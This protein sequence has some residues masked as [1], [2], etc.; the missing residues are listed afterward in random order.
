MKG[1]YINSATIIGG[2]YMRV[3]KLEVR[4]C[5]RRQKVGKAS[6]QKASDFT[7]GFIL[8]E[9]S[10]VIQG[11]T[12]EAY[13][14]P[15][16][17]VRILKGIYDEEEKQI[18]FLK[19][20]KDTLAL[21]VAYVFQCLEEQGFFYGFDFNVSGGFFPKKEPKGSATIKLEE[22]TS[23]KEKYRLMQKIQSKLNRVCD[24]V[25]AQSRMKSTLLEKSSEVLRELLTQN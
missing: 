4:F 25:T 20:C 6:P 14:T 7:G 11:Y 8:D 13:S 22:I 19:I 1:S 2:M 21:P 15:F 5:K 24:E 23:R 18:A 17:L 16:S 12:I 9:Q 10:G 3:F